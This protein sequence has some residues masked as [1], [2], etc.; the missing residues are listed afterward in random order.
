[1]IFPGTGTKEILTSANPLWEI[2]PTK[3][4]KSDIWLAEK[5]SVFSRAGSNRS[6][7]AR[8]QHSSIDFQHAV[9][10]SQVAGG[11][12]GLRRCHRISSELPGV[13]EPSS[14]RVFDAGHCSDA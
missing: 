3:S 6:S 11:R 4:C 14:H 1:M 7:A 12:T 13:N 10:R 8:L 5:A 9:P 2:S